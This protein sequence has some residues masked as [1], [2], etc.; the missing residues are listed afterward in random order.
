MYIKFNDI[1]ND[2]NFCVDVVLKEAKQEHRLVPQILHTMSSTYSNDPKNLAINAP[3]GEGKSYVL[4]KCGNL[5]PK[6]DI[7]FLSGMTDKALFHRNG[8]LII[9]NEQGE[10]IPIDEKLK[11]IEESIESKEEEKFNTKDNNLKQA[12]SSEIRNL[13]REKKNLLKNSMKLI[14]L[15]HKILVFLD[16]PPS[17]LLTAIMTLLSHDQYEV[18]YHFVDTLNGIKTKTNVLRGWPTVIFAQTIDYSHHPRWPEIQ[19]RFLITNPKMSKEKYENAIDL[20]GNKLGL[21]DFAYEKEV[22]SNEDKDKAREIIKGLKE[23]I[24][25]LTENIESGKNNV[26]IPFQDI[27]KKTIPREK[28]SDMTFAIR[29]FGFLNNV[30]FVNSEKRPKLIMRKEG[31]LSITKYP[32]ALFEDLSEALFLMEYSDGV[33]PY[34]LEWYYEVFLEAYNEKDGPDSKQ[35]SKG[36]LV[37]EVRQGVTTE[38]LVKKTFEILNKT[39]TKKQI[40]D[41]YI[42]PLQNQGYIDGIKSNIDGREKIH[43][44]I[45]TT[46]KNKK[47]FEIG[48][49]NNF[50]H[51]RK[52][53]IEK[54]VTFPSKEYI[55]SKI[56]HILEY[57]ESNV[58][59]QKIVDHEEKDISIEELVDR[60]YNN[61]NN[62]FKLKDNNKI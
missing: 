9:K 7:I 44:P 58:V 10:Y 6:E 16:T 39:Y 30:S 62:F 61:G 54:S 49:S 37:T 35:N 50:L 13:E 31:C 36:D 34:V 14:D 47:L 59:F 24:L 56:E 23:K 38:D 25:S 4:I 26:I 43:Y 29:L 21:P 32:F 15:R 48:E 52:L 45:V 57:S 42:Y 28:A 20:I 12:L 51:K 2:L 3:P 27:I 11:V 22:I 1:P 19:R 18:E 55:K 17:G 5:F 8:K 41:L 53:I 60:Y 46:E 33:R 40:L